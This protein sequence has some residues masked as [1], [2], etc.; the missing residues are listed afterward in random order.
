MNESINNKAVFRTA[1]VTLADTSGYIALDMF[2]SGMVM[3]PFLQ[4][5]P[6]CE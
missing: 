3:V 6:K 2:W 5:I 4:E 1:P